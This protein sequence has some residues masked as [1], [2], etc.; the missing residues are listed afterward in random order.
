MPV[1]A[2]VLV[3]VLCA[4]VGAAAQRAT[5][6]GGDAI[7][8]LS[9]TCPMHPDIVESRPG[10]CPL[11]KMPLVPV[12]LDTAWM[13]PVHTT[14]M[15][16]HEGTCRICRR[17]MIQARVAVTWTCLAQ[18]GIERLEPGSCADGSA[19][20]RR[21]TLRPHGN[22]NPQHGGQFFMAPDNWHH[23]EGTYPR[24]RVFRLYLYDDYARPLSAADLKRVQARVVT[25]ETFEP[26]TRTTNELAAFPLRVGG[27]GSYLEGRIE[28]VKL[29]AEMTAKVR[30]K[31]GAPE[32][33]F[34]FTFQT[35]TRE[36]IV[37]AATA[38]PPAVAPAPTRRTAPERAAAAP[39][40]AASS[41]TA[42]A[43][44]ASTRQDAD[45]PPVTTALD[46]VDP[47]MAPLEIPATM[48]GMVEE[49][50][51]RER[52]IRNFIEQG[53]FGAVWVPAFHA[54]DLAVALEPHIG[55]LSPSARAIAEPA[56][57]EVVR[58]AWLL[59]AFGDVGN[60]QQLESAHAAFA[61][62]VADVVKAFAEV[63]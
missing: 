7:P 19:M 54:K 15:D 22:H 41:A 16:D 32:Y 62:A 8:P 37:A 57:Q 42:S 5:T 18:P 61:A 27:N 58:L 17:A 59:D 48:G 52:Y 14:V 53:N 13:C 20:V 39:A 30:I 31:P 43:S 36:P 35:L 63:G 24:D 34:D 56:L 29:P 12:R 44:P 26:A 11:C 23:L 49:L 25:R 28:A 33:R 6:R 3:V 50:Q 51:R 55:H 1:K 38:R 40:S 46:S 2:A 10:S 9:M 21:R 4:A 47:A 60:R 45:G